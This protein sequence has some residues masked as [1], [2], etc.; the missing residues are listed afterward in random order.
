MEDIKN[1]YVVQKKTGKRGGDGERARAKE[2]ETK[3]KQCLKGS[4]GKGGGAF[5]EV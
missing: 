3:W 5:E 1:N 4:Q 2:R